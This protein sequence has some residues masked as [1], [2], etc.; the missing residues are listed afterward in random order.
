MNMR[1]C[2]TIVAA[3]A[4]TGCR[5][6]DVRPASD[7]VSILVFGDTGYDYHWLGADDHAEAFTGRA[8][9]I[10]ELT[11]W[12]EENR[13]IENFELPPMHYAEQ[14]GGYVMATGLW[15]VADTMRQWCVPADRCDFGVMLGDNIYPAGASLGVDGRDDAA[16]FDDLL[17]RPYR[18][19]RDQDPDFVIYPVLGNHDWETSR[20]GA[21][22]QV[23][24]LRN[25]PLYH[26]DGLYYRA[27]PAADVELFAIDT[28][29]LLAAET[30]YADAIGPDG[31]PVKTGVIEAE[32]PWAAPQ[33][34]EARMVEWLGEALADST[35]RWKL[36]IGHHPLWSSSGTK[37]EEADVLRELLLPI[38]CR[39][40]DAYLVGHEHTL[41]VHTDDCSTAGSGAGHPPL[42]LIVSGAAA[43]QRP[44]HT[45]FVKWQDEQYPQKTT[46][47]ARGFVWGFTELVLEGDEARVTIVTVPDSNDGADSE[48]RVVFTSTFGRR[49]GK[50]RTDAR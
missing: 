23:E 40:A 37:H 19:L 16:R 18:G 34:A 42:P 38:L 44:V 45:T 7:R 12:I 50:E 28:T 39:Y 4:L 15:A 43:K 21:M 13:P 2:L 30:V 11:D 3:L 29:V 33:G 17:W 31:S 24:Y 26:M 47:F 48:S 22:L 9:I 46:L 27:R 10:D 8:F 36:V 1:L 49:S 14:T 35:A 6:E 25:S 32:V 20:A 41:E 5:D